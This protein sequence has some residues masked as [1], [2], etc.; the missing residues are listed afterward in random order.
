MQPTD[1][2]LSRNP[3]C[4]GPN[5][6]KKEKMSS[7]F[8]EEVFRRQLEKCCLELNDSEEKLNEYKADEEDE[9]EIM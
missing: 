5:G 1:S 9:F 6:R 7:N 8:Q 2:E 3:L 4:Q